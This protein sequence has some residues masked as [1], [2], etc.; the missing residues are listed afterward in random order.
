M[1]SAI[2]A[3]NAQVRSASSGPSPRCQGSR[4]TSRWTSQGRLSTPEQFRNIVLRSNS[5][6]SSLRLG[7][8]ARVELGQADYSDIVKFNGHAPSGLGLT[9]ATG[10][11]R[12]I[13]SPT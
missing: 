4:S 9:L 8:V 7:D 6:G 12:S 2:T 13:P 3:Q 1:V 10:P 5:D 11:M